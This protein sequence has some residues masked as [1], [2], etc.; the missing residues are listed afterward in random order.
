MTPPLRPAPRRP[1]PPR[2]PPELT[3]ACVLSYVQVGHIRRAPYAGACGWP[4]RSTQGAPDLRS[5][6]IVSQGITKD[7]RIRRSRCGPA[8][9]L[10]CSHH[11]EAPSCPPRRSGGHWPVRTSRW[12]AGHCAFSDRCATSE[13]AKLSL[14]FHANHTVPATP[15]AKATLRLSSG[16]IRHSSAPPKAAKATRMSRI[17]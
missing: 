3:S 14:P 12:F 13:E 4:A 10:Q 2:P 17:R 5:G 6:W 16:D 7:H 9:R 1:W 8:R 11:A 15:N